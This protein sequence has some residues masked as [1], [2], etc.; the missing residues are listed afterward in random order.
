MLLFLGSAFL[1][2]TT[3]GRVV[4]MPLMSVCGCW[5]YLNARE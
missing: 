4:F 1:I 3:L 2:R 5:T